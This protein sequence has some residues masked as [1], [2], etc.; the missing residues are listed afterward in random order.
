MKSFQRCV[1]LEF[2]FSGNGRL[3]TGMFLKSNFGSPGLSNPAGSFV[4]YRCNATLVPPVTCTP[5][6]QQAAEEQC[7]ILTESNGP[8]APCRSVVPPHLYFESCVYDQCAT[9]GSFEQ[10]CNDLASY[11]AA[12]AQAGVTL[13]D[14]TAHTICGKFQLVSV[15]SAEGPRTEWTRETEL[16]SHSQT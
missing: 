13:G 15:V 5:S 8:F 3:F 7:Q 16:P 1:R 6:Q 11:A 12:C 4:R 14:W 10:L 9:G 2:S